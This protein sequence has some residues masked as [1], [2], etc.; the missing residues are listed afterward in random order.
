VQVFEYSSFPEVLVGLLKDVV[1]PRLS[2]YKHANLT[3][4]GT[5][6]IRPQQQNTVTEEVSP[7]VE[8]IQILD[9][10]CERIDV[11]PCMFH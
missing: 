1:K 8:T 7:S 6:R 2:A 4:R 11:R 9:W 5:Q 10:V 3:D